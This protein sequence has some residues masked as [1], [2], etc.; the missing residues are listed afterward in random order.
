MNN[1]YIYAIA[2]AL[3]EN[4][5]TLMVG[6]GFS[7]NATKISITDKQFLNW[8]ELSDLFYDNIYDNNS[9]P[10][11]EYNSPLRL[12]QELEVTIGRPKLENI[13]KRAIP[14][15]DYAP[16]ALYSKLMELPWRDIFTTNYDTLLERAAEN[17]ISRRY[18]IVVTQE[19][20]INS[21]NAPRIIKLHGSFPSHRPFIITEEDYRTYPTKFAAMVNTVQQ[22][23]LEN[24]FC[25][26]GFSCE[27]PNFINWIGWIHDNLG[28]SNSQKI[29]MITVSHITEAK[30]KLLF[31]RNIIV[32]DL[33]ELWPNQNIN[34]RL[35][36]LLSTLNREVEKNHT[37]NNW[38]D[39][40]NIY[41]T[42]PY[43]ADITHLINAMQSL[44]Q[45]YPGWIFLP[46]K[47]KNKV[48]HLLPKFEYLDKL[49]N[50]PHTDQI[51]YMYEYVILMNT[52]G[53]PITSNTVY[54]F[55]NILENLRL[56]LDEETKQTL[57]YKTQIIYLHL[58]RSFRELGNWDDYEKC[59]HL[60][61]ETKLTYDDKQFL[62]ASDCWKLLF[63]LQANE[64]N[65]KLNS[66]Q[67]ANGDVYW[68]LIKSNFLA[69]IGESFKAESILSNSLVQVRKQLVTSNKIDYLSSIEESIVSLLNFIRQAIRTTY[70]SNDDSKFE[71]CIHSSDISWWE[72]NEK[73]CLHINNT[74]INKQFEQHINFDLSYTNTTNY[75]SYDEN[76][77]YSLE[78][79]R[80]F[81]Q[82]GH[83]FRLNNITNT[84]GL[85]STLQT[86]S[87]DYPNWCLIQILISRH[88]ER[89]DLLFSRSLLSSMSQNEI[90]SIT[91]HY[92]DIC[93]V[94]MNNVNPKNVFIQKS[95]YEQ[96]ARILPQILARLCYKCSTQMLDNVLKMTLDLCLGNTRANFKGIKHIFKGLFR[97]YTLKEQRERINT[98]LQFPIYIDI[99]DYRDPINFIAYQDKKLNLDKTVYNKNIFQ[100]KE[101]IEN[102]S[103]EEKEQAINR[104]I[105]LGQLIN[106]SKEDSSYLCN[107]LSDPQNTNYLY[108]KYLLNKENTGY[109]KQIFD[110]TINEIESE[111]KNNVYSYPGNNYIN[112]IN[113]IPSVK[114]DDID[115]HRIFTDLKELVNKYKNYFEF[116]S[117]S[118]QIQS[119]LAIAVGVLSLAANNHSLTYSEKNSIYE[120]LDEFKS[121]YEFPIAIEIIK[122]YFV[123]Y[124]PNF[125]QNNTLSKLNEIFWFCDADEINLFTVIFNILIKFNFECKKRLITV[126]S[127]IMQNSLYRILSNDEDNIFSLLNLCSS[128][129]ENNI[130]ENTNNKLLFISLEK[131]LNDTVIKKTDPD[132]KSLQKLQC[133]KIACHIAKKLYKLDIETDVIKKWKQVSE[134]INEFPEIRNINFEKDVI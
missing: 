109:I 27:D 129:I 53:R 108:I 69:L 79:L 76:Y 90:D 125:D 25:M 54:K 67:L 14:D 121:I 104:F 29:Y 2:Q 81:E 88:E 110:V 34:E 94:L 127:N 118:I 51:S 11:K 4:H 32:I 43:E 40:N 112:L 48:S 131:I 116:N 31:E 3:Y 35:T 80:F 23:L 106:L 83:S 7:K 126:S 20:L 64:L 41:R 71:K 117:T 57:I 30:R 74:K 102:S 46:W 63:K 87:N 133:R 61:D 10:G 115:I 62:Y 134:D 65:E 73:Y 132:Q 5:A 123:D 122:S 44:N 38:F 70:N 84:K 111:C 114:I 96:S 18:N 105:I 130:L 15:L 1:K 45:S 49:D 36:H 50:S 75:S 39:F 52:C 16:S 101:L 59:H 60:I 58:L 85:N 95:I 99:N 68:P 86:I 42:I 89:L 97:S 78:Y 22:S 120:Y 72:E 24:V 66:W 56:K 9:G 8:N 100:L 26:I 82:T 113:I 119:S 107:L 28:K 92:L 17:V 77:F 91:Q 21:N 128:I 37:K 47:M 12:A 93:K 55:W 13:L 98:V 124:S 103:S 33:E 6:A 19:D